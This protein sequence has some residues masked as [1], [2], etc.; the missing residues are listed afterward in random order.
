MTLA[1]KNDCP[2]LT[3]IFRWYREFQ[4]GNFTL[5]DAEREGRPRTSVTEENITAVRTMLVEGESDIPTGIVSW[6]VGCGRPGYPGVY[7]RVAKYLNWL[8]FNLDES[9]LCT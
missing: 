9:C 4:R 3:T 1:L 7:T 6:G 2:Y 8:K 5:E